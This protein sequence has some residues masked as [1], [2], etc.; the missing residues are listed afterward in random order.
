MKTQ[1]EKGRLQG[2]GI[3]ILFVS[4]FIFVVLSYFQKVVLPKLLP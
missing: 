2:L 1:R 4:W 3:A